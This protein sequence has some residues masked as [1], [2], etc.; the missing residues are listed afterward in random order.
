M[1]PAAHKTIQELQIKAHEWFSL[2]RRKTPQGTEYFEIETSRASGRSG[3]PATQPAP[4]PVAS[5]PSQPAA[6]PASSLMSRAL[7]AAIDATDE[8]KRH[9]ASRG[10]TIEFTSEDV[11]CIAN[12]FYIQYCRTSAYRERDAA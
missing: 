9:A 1:T 7:I 12:T 2:V 11:R 6:M 5:E 8:A 4:K 10:L 3:I